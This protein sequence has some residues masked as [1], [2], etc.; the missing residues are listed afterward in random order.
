MRVLSARLRAVLVALLAAL[1]LIGI[2][3]PAT[4]FASDPPGLSR[5]MYALG[6]AESGGNYYARNA[7]SGAYGKYQIMPSSWRAWADRYLGDPNAKPTPANQEIVATAKVRALY[8]GLLSWRRVAYWWLTGSSRTTGW[9]YYATRYVNRVMGYYYNAS[10]ADI[11][12]ATSP[13]RRYSE[14]SPSITYSG[15]WRSASHRGYAGDAVRYATTAGARATFAFNGTRVIW[16]GPV[17]PTRGQAR[18][19]IDGALVKTVDLQRSSFTARKAVFTRSWTT[20]GKHTL[21]IEVVGTAG[22]P[23]VA[24]DE[25][26]VAN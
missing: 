15:S 24:I 26:A 19:F 4:T 13:L 3:G 6:R 25:L 7:T 10:A 17:G 20:P 5:F 9:S 11:A 23:Y 14:K 22:H 8:K 21:V 2:S 18:V 12:G 16:Y 1:I